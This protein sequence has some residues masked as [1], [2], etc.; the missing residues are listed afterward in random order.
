MTIEKYIVQLLYRHQCVTV[1]NFGA[2]LTNFYSAEVNEFTNTFLPPRKVI[3]FNSLLKN[4]DGLLAN[5]IAE[6]S[7]ISYDD[8]VLAIEAAVA[9]WTENF[10]K[11]ISISLS[12]IGTL[13]KNSF[14]NIIFEPI[15]DAN[16]LTT[17]FGLNQFNVSEISKNTSAQKVV[18]AP[19][20]ST[21]VLETEQRSRLNFLKYA[22]AITI[23]LGTLGVIGNNIY[24]KQV[25]SQNQLVQIEVQKA[26]H[27]K[28][29]EATFVI[30]NPFG[31]NDINIPESEMAFHIVAGKFRNIKNAERLVISLTKLGH[32]PRIFDRDQDGLS[33]VIF[34]SFPT[35]GIASKSLEIIQKNENS[36]A[37]ILIKK[38]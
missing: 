7:K 5:H 13:T 37:W 38:L 18:I 30:P 10:A 4:N 33:Q 28:I 16:F 25:L 19:Q 29:Q 23:G 21:V 20:N 3:S 17:S 2:F 14:G 15:E 24:N 11:N 35:F 1:T 27:Q 12:N 31:H 32:K 36:D 9:K 6:T 8:A 34:G 22:A 26:V